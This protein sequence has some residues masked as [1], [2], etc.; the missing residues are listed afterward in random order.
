MNLETDVQLYAKQSRG[1][2]WRPAYGQLFRFEPGLFV[3]HDFVERTLA[4]H[5]T[6]SVPEAG[7]YRS[8]VVRKEKTVMVMERTHARSMA[9]N[10]NHV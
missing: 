8:H 3:M 2:K 7:E 6:I 4:A 9:G 5:M 10:T 1:R